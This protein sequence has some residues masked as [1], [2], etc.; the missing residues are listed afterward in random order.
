MK[1]WAP[2]SLAKCQY[3]VSEVD[4]NKDIIETNSDT[5]SREEKLLLH[6]S[7]AV[8]VSVIKK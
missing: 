7:V 5:E 2:F 8:S 3:F 1:K 6:V 4:E